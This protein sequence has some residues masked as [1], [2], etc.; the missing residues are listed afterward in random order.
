MKQHNNYVQY[1]S[2]S[3]RNK[4]LSIEEYFN[5][6]KPYLKDIINNL[7]ISDTWKIQLVISNHFNNDKQHLLHSKSENIEI[8]ISDKADQVIK[9][10]FWFL[11][12][13]Y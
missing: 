10:I 1:E 4:T 2:K 9:R 3:N 13:R 6:I 8:I 12:N 5:K 7:K 11:K